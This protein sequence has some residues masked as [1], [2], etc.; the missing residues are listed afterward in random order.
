MKELRFLLASRGQIQLLQMK[1]GGRAGFGESGP[2][3]KE[4]GNMYVL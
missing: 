2:S 3:L 4:C 1:E